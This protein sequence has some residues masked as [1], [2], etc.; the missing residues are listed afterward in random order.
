MYINY[1]K[2]YKFKNCVKFIFAFLLVIIQSA[3]FYF[4]W[5]FYYNELMRIPYLMKGNYFVS[6]I[7]AMVFIAFMVVFDCSKYDENS[8]S[9]NIFSFTLT[10]FFTNILI[11]FVIIIPTYSRGFVAITPLVITGMK[12]EIVAIVWVFIVKFI[13]LKL[14]KPLPMLLISDNSNIDKLMYKFSERKDIYNIV[15]YI[16]C[17]RPLKEIKE[18]CDKFYNV[19]VGDI[20]SETRNDILKYCFNVSNNIYIMP[21]LSDIIVKNSRIMNIFDTPFYVSNND[22]I[23]IINN[24]VKRL[25]DVVISALAIIIFLPLMIIVSILIKL[26]DGGKV[27]FIQN[28]VTKDNKVFKIIKFRSMTESDDKKVIP[29]KKEDNRVTKVGKVIRKYHI[30]EIPQVFNV[31]IGNMSMV[32]PRPERIEHVELYSKQIEEFKYRLRVKAGITGLAQI[33]GRYNTSAYDKLK[34]DLIYIKN[35]SLLFDIELIFKTLKVFV[36]KENTEGFDNK[37]SEFITR[38][39]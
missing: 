14:Y 24:I 35:Q 3:F 4:I 9:N 18:K 7:Y 39:A 31:F 13:L 8:I 5:V 28:R 17:D 11:Y 16:D 1:K 15:E 29:T 20:K 6:F 30:D 32:G 27:F 10:I 38:N 33:Y 25:F 23:G 12:Q 22:D 21:K 34:L 2:K 26:E 19:I 37:E 36:M